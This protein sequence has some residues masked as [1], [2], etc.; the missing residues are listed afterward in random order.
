MRSA[1]VDN[2]LFN[3]PAHHKLV[4]EALR[5]IIFATVK[6]VV[7]AVKW[8]VPMYSSDNGFL[9]YINYDRKSKCVVLAMVEGFMMDDK[10][11]LFLP[12][13][14]NIKKIPLA[15]DEDLP[16]RK[17]QY[18]LREGMRINKTKT[19]NFMSIK[20][21]KPLAPKKTRNPK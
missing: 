1:A 2:F 9:C 14:S 12:G 20:K 3:V 13:T 4:M 19:K 8:N 18:Y 5:D 10:Y 6:D 11:R 16:I 21:V 7:E 17:L 15:F